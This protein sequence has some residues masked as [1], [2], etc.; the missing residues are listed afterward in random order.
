MS[1]MY[2][3]DYGRSLDAENF[4]LE[5]VI[6]YLRGYKKITNC[7]DVIAKADEVVRNETKVILAARER[8]LDA[9]RS[10][11]EDNSDDDGGGGDADTER[12]IQRPYA[13][14]EK[15][16]HSPGG[17]ARKTRGRSHGDAHTRRWS[18]GKPKPVPVPVVAPEVRPEDSMSQRQ[19]RSGS[20]V[21]FAFQSSTSLSHSC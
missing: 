16:A 6:E 8:V 14:R 19:V 15:D 13:V 9:F 20:G 10:T 21:S 11:V 5:P 17:K 4:L 12:G 3:T 7:Q 18:P 2:D 1:Y